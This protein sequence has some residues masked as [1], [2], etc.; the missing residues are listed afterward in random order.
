MTSEELRAAL[1]EVVCSGEVDDESH[2]AHP[3]VSEE[4]QTELWTWLRDGSVG[5]EAAPP[6]PAGCGRGRQ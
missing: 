2:F 6:A 3:G 4:M 5:P 1:R